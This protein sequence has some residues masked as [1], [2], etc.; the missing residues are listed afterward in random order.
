MVKPELIARCRKKDQ[1]AFGALYEACL[2]YVYTIV[3]GYIENQDIRKDLLQEIFARIF[4]HLSDYRPEK[5]EF[6]FW[7]RRI[8]VNQCLMFLRDKQKL[9]EFDDLTDMDPSL[10]GQDHI[11]LQH[12]DPDVSEVII[13]HMP[14]GY[15]KI[16]SLVV[17]KG[18]SHEE[19]SMELGIT[20]ETSRSQLTRSKQWLRK[21]LLT[22]K[23]LTENGFFQ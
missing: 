2:P 11:D 22:N 17:M 23:T 4:L 13:G 3:K 1:Q 5:G 18:Y 19:V 21:F 7:I 20:T 14:P 9:Y 15:R 12:L 6:R 10:E 8:A 16:F